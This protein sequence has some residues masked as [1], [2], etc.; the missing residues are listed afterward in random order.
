MTHWSQPVDDGD[1]NGVQRRGNKFAP[2]GREAKTKKVQV[3]EAVSHHLW[4]K[5][6]KMS[7][8]EEMSWTELS[9]TLYFKTF[10]F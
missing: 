10:L 4:Q 8:E 1:S 9:A 2:S 7:V 6:T 5:N 3:L